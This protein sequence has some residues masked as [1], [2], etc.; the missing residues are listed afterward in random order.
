MVIEP[1]RVASTEWQV[2]RTKVFLRRCVHEPLEEMRAQV[3]RAK[4]ILVQS[5]WRGYLARS[6][7][8][9]EY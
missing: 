1:L 9:H 7:Q 6:G 3:V 4:A 5:S 2:G 8:S